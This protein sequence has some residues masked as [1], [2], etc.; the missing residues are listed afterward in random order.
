MLIGRDTFS[1]GGRSALRH[2]TRRSRPLKG[3][4]H[5]MDGY[6]VAQVRAIATSAVREARNGDMFLDRIQART[7]VA[8][9]IINEAE[10]SRLVF[11]AVRMRSRDIRPS[12]DLERSWWKS[13]VAAPA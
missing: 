3:F 8:F 13:A 7:G 11:L 4:R 5:L 2:S 9:D 1:S 12:A 10:E 6:G